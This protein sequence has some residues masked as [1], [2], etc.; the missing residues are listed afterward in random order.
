[1]NW[2]FGQLFVGDNAP[3]QTEDPDN[4]TNDIAKG[5]VCTGQDARTVRSVFVS[6]CCGMARLTNIR[7]SQHINDAELLRTTCCVFSVVYMS[8]QRIHDPKWKLFGCQMGGDLG[9]LW[10]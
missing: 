1:M 3:T 8:L 9:Q 4:Q 7:I 2:Q 10:G 5:E 6:I